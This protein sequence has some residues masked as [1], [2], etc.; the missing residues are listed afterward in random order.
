MLIAQ[1]R[2]KSYADKHCR[3]LEFEVGDLVYLKVSPIRGVM[4]FGKKGKLSP[5][6]VGPFQVAKVCKSFG[7]IMFMN[8]ISY[9]SNL[10]YEERCKPG[11]EDQNE[12]H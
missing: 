4:R 6:Y 7:E 12:Y 5:R 11:Y 9:E 1:S 3:T 2:Q 8:I 10:T